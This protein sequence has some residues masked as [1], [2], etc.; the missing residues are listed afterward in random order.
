M[1]YDWLHQSYTMK[2]S[3]DFF[4]KWCFED[5][6]MF[7]CLPCLKADGQHVTEFS[8]LFSSDPLL[9]MYI[10]TNNITGIC[11]KKNA[12]GVVS[13]HFCFVLLSQIL[14]HLLVSCYLSLLC[15][16]SKQKVICAYI[17]YTSICKHPKTHGGAPSHPKCLTWFT[18]NLSA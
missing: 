16:W 1:F 2:T 5:C 10:A 8:V 6:N 12:P 4:F 13:C 9:Q 15:L 7:Y 18:L 11:N 3:A 14:V 17:Q